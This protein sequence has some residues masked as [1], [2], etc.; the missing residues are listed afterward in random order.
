MAENTILYPSLEQTS[1]LADS[2]IRRLLKNLYIQDGLVAWWD[3]EWN[4]GLGVHDSNATV[5]KDLVGPYTMTASAQTDTWNATCLTMGTTTWKITPKTQFVR[6]LNSPQ[7]VNESYSVEMVLSHTDQSNKCI[8]GH[9]YITLDIHAYHAYEA[10]W[11]KNGTDVYVGAASG[12]K[13]SI[14]LSGAR[15]GSTANELIRWHYNGG[16]TQSATRA[17]TQAA[18]SDNFNV[19]VG[20]GQY[21]ERGIATANIYCIRLY[22]RALTDAEVAFNYATDKRRFNL[23]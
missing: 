16:H 8:F 23:P 12:G 21:P 3:G 19:G 10:V 15:S 11:L 18:D 6:L 17:Y 5:W 7:R 9:R 4:A 14:S 20:F 1:E 2:I 13:H 22:N